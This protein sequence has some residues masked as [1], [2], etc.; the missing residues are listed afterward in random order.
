MSHDWSTD[1][2]WLNRCWKNNPDFFYSV[3]SD[4][5]FSLVVLFY[6]TW[7][8]SLILSPSRLVIYLLFV[9]LLFSPSLWTTAAQLKW[10][11]LFC[12]VCFHFWQ[13]T[14]RSLWII[15]GEWSNRLWNVTHTQKQW[16]SQENTSKQRQKSLSLSLCIYIATK[17]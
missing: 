1:W 7:L 4:H 3:N 6:S 17:K 13:I 15:R 5:V 11:Q 14:Q 2:M 12:H 10:S 9:C 16:P 8:Y